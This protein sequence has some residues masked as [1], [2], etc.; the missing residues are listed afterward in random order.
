MTR[1]FCREQGGV[2]SSSAQE[3]DARRN[4]QYFLRLDLRYDLLLILTRC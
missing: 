1:I 4:A 2:R 3:H